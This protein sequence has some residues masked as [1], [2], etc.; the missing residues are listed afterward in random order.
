M[1]CANHEYEDKLLTRANLKIR[2]MWNEM[3]AKFAK[4]QTGFPDV[5]HMSMT[6][7]FI[8]YTNALCFWLF[9]FYSLED[10]I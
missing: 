5:S 1:N 9:L 3:N 6:R 7:H 4:K 10:I 8:T 2:K